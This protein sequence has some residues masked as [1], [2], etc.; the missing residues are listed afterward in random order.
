[1][2]DREADG[3]DDLVALRDLA[4]Q[5]ELQ[6]EAWDVPPADLWDRIAAEAG[7]VSAP[8]APGGPAE[9]ARAEARAEVVPL[10]RR[11]PR[12]GWALA[13][14]AA[15][16]ILVVAALAVTVGDGSDVVASADLEPLGES[17]SGRAELVDVDGHSRLRLETAGID[18]G[19]GFFEVWLLDPDVTRLVSLGPLRADGTYDLPPGLDPRQLPVVDVSV[20]PLDGNPTHSGDSVLRGELTF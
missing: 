7:V 4:G 9:V 8:G 12:V 13:A 5:L 6:P 10:R 11:R 17:G 16:G 14:A 19:D 1:V 20:E 3:A 18:A 15:A 2:V